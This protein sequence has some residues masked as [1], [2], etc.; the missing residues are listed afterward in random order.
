VIVLSG[1]SL[2][3]DLIKDLIVKLI[4][5]HQNWNNIIDEPEDKEEYVEVTEPHEIQSILK[6]EEELKAKRH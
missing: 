5:N 4:M 2:G 3:A 6:A 1:L